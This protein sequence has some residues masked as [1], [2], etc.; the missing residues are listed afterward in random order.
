MRQRVWTMVFACA[1]MAGL[2]IPPADVSAQTLPAPAVQTPP[3][4]P[5]PS[6]SLQRP[7]RHPA[8]ASVFDDLVGDLISDFRRLPSSEAATIL[9]VGAIGAAA[10]G[11]WDRRAT[12]SLSGASELRPLFSAG[13]TIG[14]AHVQL[15][16][17]LTTYTMGR[18]TSNDTV[19]AI[20]ADVFRAQLMTQGVTQGI[21]LAVGR[22]RP[23]GTGYSFPSGHS[24]TAF[25]TA[26]VL[27]R[28][29]GWKAGI[30]AHALAAYVAASRL[31][32][33]RHFLSDVTFGAA[34][35]IV[36]GRSITVGRGNTRFA[37]APAAES[38][39][40]SINFTL[41]ERD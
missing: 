13:Q 8:G 36:A 19:R 11:Q 37:V 41:I 6:P 24:A 30:P 28:H 14:G 2:G 31:Q 3:A 17:A 18:L 33:N 27:Q 10:A 40:A 39:G 12:L 26:T 4:P 16:G 34:L 35:G 23:D 32:I 38:G 7:S 29:L 1:M 9:S 21:K 22:S 25:A 5:V 20:G 15:A